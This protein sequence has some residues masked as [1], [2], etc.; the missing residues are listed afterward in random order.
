[1]TLRRI[2]WVVYSILGLVYVL[3]GFAVMLILG[4]LQQRSVNPGGSA[5]T[6]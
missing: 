1:M 5:E 3:L 4:V 2:T 6:I